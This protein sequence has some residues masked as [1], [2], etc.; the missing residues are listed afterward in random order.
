M[1]YDE[2]MKVIRDRCFDIWRIM[3]SRDPVFKVEHIGRKEKVDFWN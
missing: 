3:R 1:L 2:S